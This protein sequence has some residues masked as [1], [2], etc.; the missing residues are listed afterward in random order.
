MIARICDAFIVLAAISIIVGIISR[1]LMTPFPFGIEAQ[2]Y[3]QFT[4][5]MLLFA[6]A[7]GIREI[8]RTKRKD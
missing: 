2:A 8:L 4:H 5:G 1:L 7:I 3:L 6:I